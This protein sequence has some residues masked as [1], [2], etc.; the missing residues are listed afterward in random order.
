LYLDN[1]RDAGLLWLLSILRCSIILS[2]NSGRFGSF[3]IS[4]TAWK[5]ARGAAAATSVLLA[6][7][8]LTPSRAEASCGDYVMVGGR[9]AG[10][11][12]AGLSN[13]AGHDM[14]G[15][16]DPATPRCHGPTCSNGSIPPSAPA[17]KIEVTVERWAIP[18][19][20]G[21]PLL[22]ESDFLLADAHAVP[23]EGF[24]LSI[25]RPPR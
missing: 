8:V 7:A 3:M 23:C 12:M 18:G 13:D 5:F 16:H 14:Q 19:D 20:A 22:T 21:L 2:S 17:P 1:S 10:S 25:L 11:G 15:H 24:G 6:S 4:Q 9:N